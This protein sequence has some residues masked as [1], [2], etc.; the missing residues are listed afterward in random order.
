[1]K[2]TGENRSTRVKTCPSATLSTTN[3]TWTDP[4]SN[5]GLRGGRLAANRLSH[6]TARRLCWIVHLRRPR[7]MFHEWH[8]LPI[9]RS[10][11]QVDGPNTF[12]IDPPPALAGK[13]IHNSLTGSPELGIYIKQI[14]LGQGNVIMP[15][16]HIQL[17]SIRLTT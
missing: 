9:L 5:P 4:G 10:L 3:P 2:L 13:R 8:I 6:G 14:P 1:M 17:P 11:L 16:W 15:Q 12:A 7:L